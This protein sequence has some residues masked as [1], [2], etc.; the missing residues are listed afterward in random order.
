[1]FLDKDL[2]IIGRSSPD[3]SADMLRLIADNMLLRFS[4]PLFF[5]GG[6]PILDIKGKPYRKE[7][8]G[9]TIKFKRYENK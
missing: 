8:T 7:G 4:K 1:M 5:L 9:E 6:S 2:P 3:L